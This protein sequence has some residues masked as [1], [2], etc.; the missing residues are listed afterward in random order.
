MQQMS[1]D[2]WWRAGA[3]NRLR[4]PSESR[5]SHLGSEDSP[6]CPSPAAAPG[7]LHV[8]VF[9]SLPGTQRL[10]LTPLSP[11]SAR[12]AWGGG[13]AG[14]VS[15]VSAVSESLP[16]LDPHVCVAPL[17]GR[18]GTT[19]PSHLPLSAS[20]PLSLRRR[21]DPWRHPSSRATHTPDAPL[22]GTA[23]V[24]P[25]VYP[26]PD[27]FSPPPALSPAPGPLRS[28]LG[29]SHRAGL[30]APTVAPVVST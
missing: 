7:P 1:L 27:P 14:P 17:G 15:H 25:P 3:W 30:P 23:G 29:S 9:Q 28:H 24:S 16:P 10:S 8:L 6:L 22:A 20:G 18:A 2:V 21:S 12:T 4:L 19:H 5:S 11:V 26:Q 13:G